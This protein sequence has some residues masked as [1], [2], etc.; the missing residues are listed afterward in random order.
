MGCE[1]AR[2]AASQPALTPPTPVSASTAFDHSKPNRRPTAAL[3][4]WLTPPVRVSC[5]Q[6]TPARRTIRRRRRAASRPTSPSPHISTSR[7]HHLWHPPLSAPPPPSPPL[8]LTFT[9]APLPSPSP[10]PPNP[11]P[12]LPCPTTPPPSPLYCPFPPSLYPRAAVE[13]TARTDGRAHGSGRRAAEDSLRPPRQHEVP[14]RAG[15]DQ[16]R[17][18]RE[19]RS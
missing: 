8:T 5:A 11:S 18:H 4:S 13:D 12:A 2:C 19:Y 3:R 6:C 1:P 17:T 14:G 10:R 15:G 16:A 7:Y 9:L